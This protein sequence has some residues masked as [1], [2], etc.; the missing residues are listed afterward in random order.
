MVKM[1]KIDSYKAKKSIARGKL[2]VLSHNV[3]H[4]VGNGILLGSGQSLDLNRLERLESIYTRAGKDL[5]LYVS[6]L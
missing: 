5:S 1:V 6:Y 3:P 4:V 2:V